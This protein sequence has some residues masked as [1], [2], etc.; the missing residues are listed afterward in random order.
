MLKVFRTLNLAGNGRKRACIEIVSDILLQHRVLNTRK[1]L[2][3]L[4]PDLKAK[5]FT[6]LAV[7]DPQMHPSEESRAI[8]SLFDGEI[9][10]TEKETAQG[11]GKTLKVKKLVNQKYLETELP[12]SK[13][14]LSA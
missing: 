4:L 7:I 6:T 9:A 11:L 3:A 10:I 1:W 12:L 2:S 5:G 8:I 13:E 14:K